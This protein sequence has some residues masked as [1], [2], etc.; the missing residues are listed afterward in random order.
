MN[1]LT[2]I[3]CDIGDIAYN[4]QWYYMKKSEQFMIQMMIIRA[5]KPFEMKGM[6]IFDCSL[7]AFSGVIRKKIPFK[8]KKRLFQVFFS[9][10][11]TDA[12]KRYIILY[13]FS[14]I[15]RMKSPLS[16]L[17]SPL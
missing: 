3:T 12:S 10:I 14:S 5:Q 2:T 11:L 17:Q 4:A 7:A 9:M 6:G 16:R 15:E 13:G 1:R 8:D